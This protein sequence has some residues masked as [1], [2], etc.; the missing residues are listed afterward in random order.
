MRQRE[1]LCDSM[2]NACTKDNNTV[3]HIVV[4]QIK[5][6]KK[7]VSK[8]CHKSCGD[9]KECKVGEHYYIA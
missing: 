9:I 6:I 7:I 4:R 2:I 8:T 5:S 3:I 1:C